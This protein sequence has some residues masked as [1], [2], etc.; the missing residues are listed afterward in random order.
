MQWI[1]LR[2]KG[3]NSDKAQKP[4]HVRHAIT[5]PT[6]NLL[7]IKDI[8]TQASKRNKIQHLAQESSKKY[9]CVSYG[10]RHRN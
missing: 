8:E 5:H 10:F 7:L 4:L 6:R 1:V 3:E 9:K 2:L